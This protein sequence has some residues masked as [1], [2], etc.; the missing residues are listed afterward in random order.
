MNHKGNIE[1]IYRIMIG[2]LSTSDGGID[3][4]FE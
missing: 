1:N 3:N 4:I 2:F